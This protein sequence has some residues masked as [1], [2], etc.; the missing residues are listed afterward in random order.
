MVLGGNSCNV[1]VV[2]RR[3]SGVK[4]S[5]LTLYGHKLRLIMHIGL[6]ISLSVNILLHLLLAL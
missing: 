5:R 2:L 4:C 6:S 1:H 3:V